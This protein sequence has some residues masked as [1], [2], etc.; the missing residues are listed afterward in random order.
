MVPSCVLLILALALPYF[1]I[2]ADA[3]SEV[4]QIEN[5]SPCES[6]HSEAQ[7][8]LC[9]LRESSALLIKLGILVNEG[10]NRLAVVQGA[11]HG[12]NEDREKRKHE[13]LRFGKRKHEYLRFGKRKDEFV[14]FG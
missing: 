8:I 5:F 13:Y 12:D 7:E 1:F 14:R 2:A 10:L 11:S 4:H 9:H 3:N 6:I